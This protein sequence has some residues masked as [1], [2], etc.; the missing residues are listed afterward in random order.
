MFGAI[1]AVNIPLIFVS[2]IASICAIENISVLQ[3]L[4]RKV[5]KRFLGILIFT[6]ISATFISSRFFDVISFSFS[7][8]FSPQNYMEMQKIFDLIL[9]IIPRNIMTPFVE[10]NVLQIVILA[11]LIGICITILGEKV[12]GIKNIVFELQ[13]II[14]D[15]VSIVFKIIP[16]IIF[17]CILKILL[18][19]SASEILSVWKIVAAQYLIYVFLILVMLLKNYFSY[20]TK[21]LDFLK[22]LYPACLISFTTGSGSA[23]MPK[24]LEICKEELKISKTLC[25]FYI[26][27]SH[28]MCPS[29]KTIAFINW[30]LF[31]AQFSGV[32]ITISQIFIMIFF[33]IQF[34]I[35]SSNGGNGG[36]I[37]M[38][39]LLL[40]QMNLSVDAIGL[41]MIANIFLTQISGV[42]EL[43]IRDCNL[44]DLSHKIRMMD[45][46]NV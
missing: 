32:Q 42:I 5:F 19:N 2:I 26:P 43:I 46:P 31:A 23:A 24:N 38:M 34:A 7:S 36:M 27:L 4:S 1:I 16:V 20:G 29:I 18:Q 17:L 3:D 12:R 6:T 30:T 45:T 10:E 14:I 15:M 37:A 44:L 39:T 21:I 22:K 35:S 28:P 40:T 11:F 8:E 13:K 33:S 41:I 25:D 9:S